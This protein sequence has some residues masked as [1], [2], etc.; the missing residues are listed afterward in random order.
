MA[1]KICKQKS[2]DKIDLICEQG[3]STTNN[4]SDVKHLLIIALLNNVQ[5][6]DLNILFTIN[7]T[8]VFEIYV[9]I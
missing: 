3:V 4:N 9:F 5:D 8:D 2:P 6:V 7:S 1:T